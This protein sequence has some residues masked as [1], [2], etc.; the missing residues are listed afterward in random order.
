MIV[1]VTGPESSGKTTLASDL[2]KALDMPWMPEVSRQYLTKLDRKY[3][4]NDIEYLI[5]AQF[6]Q[7]RKLQNQYGSIIL[8]TDLLTLIIWALDKFERMPVNASELLNYSSSR[9]YLLCTPD[10]PWEYDPL[11]EN[12]KDRDRLFDWYERELDH[13]SLPYQVIS[14]DREVRVSRAKEFLG[15]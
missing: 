10:I 13:L 15:I 5:E 14:G 8:D 9:R 1:V 3:N 11:R 6:E 2:S 12:P 4:F 7:E